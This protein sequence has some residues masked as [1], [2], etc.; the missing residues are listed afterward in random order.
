MRTVRRPR[1]YVRTPTLTVLSPLFVYNLKRDAYVLR[2][3]GRHVGPVLLE[4]RRRRRELPPDL[5]EMR[6]RTRAA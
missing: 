4:D 6:R 3:V 1:R 2:G 5:I